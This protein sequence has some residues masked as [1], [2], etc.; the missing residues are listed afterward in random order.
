MHPNVKTLYEVKGMHIN[1]NI[2]MAA[3]TGVDM[4]MH[5]PEDDVEA[6]KLR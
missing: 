3:R 6:T 4:R 1:E 5:L 2:I